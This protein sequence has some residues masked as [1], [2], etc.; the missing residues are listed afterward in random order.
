MTTGD[1]PARAHTFPTE[2][3]ECA[4]PERPLPY[5]RSPRKTPGSPGPTWSGEARSLVRTEGAQTGLPDSAPRWTPA[6][7][8]EPV[9]LYFLLSLPVSFLCLLR[10]C[11]RQKYVHEVTD[12]MSYFQIFFLKC[13]KTNTYM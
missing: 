3:R 10:P 11:P 7:P 2:G 13:M 1:F 8:V 12:P 5:T 9:P 4:Q 6:L